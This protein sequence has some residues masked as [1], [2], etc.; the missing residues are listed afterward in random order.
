MTGS[1][2]S[3]VALDSLV[4]SPICLP[5]QLCQAWLLLI[6]ASLALHVAQGRTCCSVHLNTVGSNSIHVPHTHQAQIQDF[7]G[8]SSFKLGIRKQTQKHECTGKE[9]A[10]EHLALLVSRSCTAS[11]SHWLSAKGSGLFPAILSFGKCTVGGNNDSWWI[12]KPLLHSTS[13]ISLQ[14]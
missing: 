11:A 8:Q 2:C 6:A 12:Q 13:K 5:I 3:E 9:R 14:I 7:W 4:S 10:F 1:Y